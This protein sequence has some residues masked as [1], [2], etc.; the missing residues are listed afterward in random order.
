VAVRVPVYAV[1][2][3]PWGNGV[4]AIVKGDGWTD[5]V[6]TVSV[7]VVVA[8]WEPESEMDTLKE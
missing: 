5:V 8:D 7:T 3:T 2:T 4:A 6:E 1:P